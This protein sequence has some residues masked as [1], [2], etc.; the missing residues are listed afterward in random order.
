MS[1]LEAVISK[2][3]PF[4]KA[5]ASKDHGDAVVVVPTGWQAVHYTLHS[6]NDR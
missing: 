2:K 3:I 4:R 6:I 1:H 5:A